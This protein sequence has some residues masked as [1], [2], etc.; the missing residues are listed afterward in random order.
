L[1]TYVYIDGFNFYYGAVKDTKYKWLDFMKLCRRILPKHEILKIKYFTA[2]VSEQGDSQKPRRQETYLAAL[3]TIPQMEI[4]KGHFLVK[5]N[6]K[7]LAM[8]CDPKDKTATRQSVYVIENEEK[9]S[10]VNLAVHLVNDAHLDKFE[11]AVVISNDSD[12]AETIKIAKAPGPGMRKRISIINPQIRKNQKCAV[13]LGNLSDCHFS[14]TNADLSES[15]F[16][17]TIPYTRISKPTE[18]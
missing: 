4:I 16:S 13:Q 9:G 11:M 5:K 18:W 12:L 17:E 6:R 3:R 8:S 14:L 15:L 10:D 2:M 1:K 7:M